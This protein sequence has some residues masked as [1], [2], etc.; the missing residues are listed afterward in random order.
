RS[1]GTVRHVLSDCISNKSEETELFIV[2]DK[3]AAR[4]ARTICDRFTQAV[5]EIDEPVVDV[6]KNELDVILDNESYKSII[7]A[8]GIGICLADGA[9][10]NVIARRYGKVVLVD[11]VAAEL[12]PFLRKYVG[13]LLAVGAVY[14]APLETSGIS[15]QEFAK[16]V[17]TPSTRILI[18]LAL[19]FRASSY[20]ATNLEPDEA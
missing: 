19:R 3:E 11:S 12:L 15:E 6:E 1:E 10:L 13:P 7:A 18:E 17:M 14:H 8:L 16:Q 2:G 4:M 9:G 5:L 20:R